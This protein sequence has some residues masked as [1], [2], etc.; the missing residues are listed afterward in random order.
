MSHSLTR[1]RT[2]RPPARRSVVDSAQLTR[3]IGRELWDGEPGPVL[4]YAGLCTR[5]AASAERLAAQ[6]DERARSTPGQGSSR[7]LPSVPVA[8]NAVLDTAV[9]WA[10]SPEERDRLSAG[11]LDRLGDAGAGRGPWEDAGEPLALRSLRALDGPDGE[12][13][14]WACVEGLPDTVIA[15][16]LGSIRTDVVEDVRR[17]TAEFRERGWLAHNLRLQNPVCRT[18]AGLLDATARQSAPA[19]PVDLLEHLHQ[20]PD[21]TEAFACLRIDSNLLPSVIAEAALHWNGSAYAARRRRQLA[22]V[23]AATVPRPADRGAAPP[24]PSGGLRDRRHA[25][26]AAGVAVGLVLLVAA[27]YVRGDDAPPR[28]DR[29]PGPTEAAGQITPGFPEQP[30]ARADESGPAD[31]AEPP[32]ESSGAEPSSTGSAPPPSAASDPPSRGR[33]PAAPPACTATFDVQNTW[34]DGVQADLELSSRHALERGWVVTFRVPDGVDV[35]VWHGTPTRQGDRVTVTAAD[36]NRAYTPGETVVIGLV[37]RGRAA[38]DTWLS[39]IRVEG[40][41]CRS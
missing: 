34:P 7:G 40:R 9:A 33:A 32:E 30:G 6:A 35:E 8:L 1:T 20:C 27:L 2:R 10:A 4:T 18:Y 19:P 23:P 28:A 11:L 25:L 15:R 21:C 24:R 26:R 22:E 17:V 36:Y 38:G 16:R 37:L 41:A 39:D 29:P 3:E 13:L 14:W 12:L 5:D 31:T